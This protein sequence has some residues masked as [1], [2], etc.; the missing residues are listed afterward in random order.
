MFTAQCT[1]FIFRIFICT[2][3]MNAEF[4][5][6]KDIVRQN[7]KESAR[8]FVLMIFESFTAYLVEDHFGFK[9]YHSLFWFSNIFLLN[10]TRI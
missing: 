8:H 5:R 6:E 10:F 3:I 1:D 4:S 2:R 7:L 9:R